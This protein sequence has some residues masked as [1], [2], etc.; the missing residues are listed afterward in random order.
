M[1]DSVGLHVATLGESSTT[2]VTGIGALA[3][4]TALVCLHSI[5]TGI[6]RGTSGTWTDLE[7]SQLRKALSTTCLFATLGI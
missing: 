2:V 6:R 7:I 4:V 3:S 1:H 5:N